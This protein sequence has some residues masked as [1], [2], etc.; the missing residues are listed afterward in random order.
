MESLKLI[1][2][3]LTP[4]VDLNSCSVEEQRE[5]NRTGLCLRSSVLNI[6]PGVEKSLIISSSLRHPGLISYRVEDGFNVI[7]E[8]KLP[9]FFWY[10]RKETENLFWF[11]RS[12]KFTDEIGTL[13]GCSVFIYKDRIVGIEIPRLTQS[14]SEFHCATEEELLRVIGVKYLREY[15]ESFPSFFQTLL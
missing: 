2:R 10:W 6:S 4:D 11:A 7:A 13:F 8:V 5:F 15:S 14:L 3:V 9:R 1:Q 12:R